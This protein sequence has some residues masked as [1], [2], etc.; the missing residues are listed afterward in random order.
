MGGWGSRMPGRAG[1]KRGLAAAGLELSAASRARVPRSGSRGPGRAGKARALATAVSLLIALP[2]LLAAM[3]P[4]AYTGQIWSPF[5]LA[6]PAAVPG[7]PLAATGAAAA[8]AQARSAAVTRDSRRRAGVQA[9]NYRPSARRA[10][11][12]GGSAVV[13][14]AHVRQ[15]PAG[16]PAAASRAP[17]APQP[18]GKLPIAVG[19]VAGHPGPSSVRVT[20]AG[21]PA[22]A[23]AGIH[24]VIM[25]VA[26]PA[27]AGGA[28]GAVAV[29]LHLLVV[30]PGLRRCLGV[31]A[32]HSRI[33]CLR[34]F[35]PG[36]G[37]LPGRG[38]GQERQ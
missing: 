21:H 19:P 32:A 37:R 28:G 29:R 7:Q 35:C 3:P 17:D 34:A 8:R 12:A 23:R 10:W 15:A 24:G 25:T 36:P 6:A 14:L 9:H 13:A 2:L 1:R 11:P 27:G 38:A 5:P 33:A 22:A 20:L 18:A 26:R 30:R 16:R 31:E 4:P